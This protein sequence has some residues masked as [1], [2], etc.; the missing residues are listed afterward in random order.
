MS[1]LHI[2]DLCVRWRRVPDDLTPHHI[3]VATWGGLTPCQLEEPEPPK[4]YI[5]EPEPPK[6]YIIVSRDA[7][8]PAATL[9]SAAHAHAHAC[10]ECD[11]PSASLEPLEHLEC[12]RGDRPSPA[13]FP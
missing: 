8:P 6:I 1:L 2:P 5:I 12:S 13:R 7:P 4:I 3:K 10:C 11:G 9:G